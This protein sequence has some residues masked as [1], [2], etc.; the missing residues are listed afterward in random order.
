MKKL[1]KEDFN[2]GYYDK[3]IKEINNELNIIFFEI[4]RET[5]VTGF[6]KV[7]ILQYCMQN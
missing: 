1:G 6:V 7:L 5:E 3:T 4:L 2:D